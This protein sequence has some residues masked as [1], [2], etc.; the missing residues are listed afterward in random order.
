MKAR[1]RTIKPEFFKHEDLYDAEQE[2]G[3]PLRLAFAGLWTVCDKEGRFEWRPR[4]L[5]IE[6]MPY[7][8]V[9]F[10]RVL[11][12]L[13]TRGFIIRYRVGDKEFGCVPSF[14]K[15]QV[16]NNRESPSEI[17]EPPQAAEILTESTRAPRVNDACPTRQQH[18]QAEGEGEGEGD[19][20][21][22][23]CASAISNLSDADRLL[24]DVTQAVGLKSGHTP[25]YWMPPAATLHVWRWV[26]DLG[27]DPERIVDAARQSRSAHPE[28][29]SG[30]KA[31]D[32]V[33]K[34]LAA[35]LSA[36]P[37]QIPTAATGGRNDRSRFDTAHREYTRRIASGEIQRGPDASDP[38][39]GR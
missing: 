3:L 28:P 15:H 13:T 11:H 31:L 14:G 27:L 18:A 9:D 7:D 20:E 2:S 16:I 12:A 37:M 39:A 6:V 5:K 36:P 32:G 10:S 34:R 26:T 30:P 29:P 24:L 17:P 23:E 4:A 19:K 38:F 33:M 21:E 22:E 25:A 1:I 8:D 35:E